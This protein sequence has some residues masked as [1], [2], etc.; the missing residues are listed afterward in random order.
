MNENAKT[1]GRVKNCLRT[2]VTSDGRDVGRV[3]LY[4]AAGVWLDVPRGWL[5]DMENINGNR[6]SRDVLA[7]YAGEVRAARVVKFDRGDAF[8]VPGDIDHYSKTRRRVDLYLPAP[9]VEGVEFLDFETDTA[10]HYATAYKVP[11][12]CDVQTVSF[13]NPNP[14]RGFFNSGAVY[15]SARVNCITLTAG[16]R[17]EQ[18]ENGARVDALAASL[19]SDGVM[20]DSYNV[21][22][23]AKFYDVKRKEAATC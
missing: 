7:V 21:E 2:W 12:A 22:L 1:A 19:K 9:R 15:G 4:D 8:T 3:C 16:R 11:L 10:R 18:T 17:A 23:L 14:A 6:F 5:E 20:I 13:P